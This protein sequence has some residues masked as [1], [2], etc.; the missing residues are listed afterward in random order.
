[1]RKEVKPV[2]NNLEAMDRFMQLAANASRAASGSPSI[3]LADH[4]EMQLLAKVLSDSLPK[5]VQL[6]VS[7]SFPIN[8]SKQKDFGERILRLIKVSEKFG[9]YDTTNEPESILATFSL[10]AADKERV[11]KLCNDMRKIV[12]ASVDFDDPHKRRL[13]NRIAAI[14]QQVHANRGLFDVILGGVSDLGETLGKFGKDI[15]PLS[16]RMQ[17]V[18]RIARKNTGEYEQ[19]PAPEEIPKLP[20]PNEDDSD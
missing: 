4:D 16:D 2:A 10:P 19:I 12:F 18:A 15:K 3:S 17:E 11:L 6:I 8:G 9:A 1:M 5:K 7:G 20:S 13:L 14:E